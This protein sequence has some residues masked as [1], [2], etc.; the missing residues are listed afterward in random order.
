MSEAVSIND[1]VLRADYD[2][3]KARAEEAEAILGAAPAQMSWRGGLVPINSDGMRTVIDAHAAL[4]ATIERLR[5]WSET[6]FRNNRFS[7][8]SLSFLAALTTPAPSVEA[9]IDN[10][11]NAWPK[12]IKGQV[13]YVNSPTW[14]PTYIGPER[15]KG[16]AFHAAIYLYDED[17]KTKL[18]K[19]CY[20]RNGVLC[21]AGRLDDK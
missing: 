6:Q 1:V 19:R 15:R 13:E 12:W 2:A 7:P 8:D 9:A 21:A 10:T 18:D 20:F 3:M 14:T 17:G 16:Q 4:A 11:G 5:V